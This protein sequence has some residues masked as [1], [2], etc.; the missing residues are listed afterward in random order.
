M[1]SMTAASMGGQNYK[2]PIKIRG[3]ENRG[4]FKYSWGHICGIIHEFKSK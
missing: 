3:S 1:L 4:L 2:V